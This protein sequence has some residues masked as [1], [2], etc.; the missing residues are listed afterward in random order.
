MMLG[1]MNL[2]FSR[3][4]HNN[5]RSFTD[6]SFVQ[7]WPFFALDIAKEIIYIQISSEDI[8]QSNC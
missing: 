6:Y 4:I 1:N 7:L 8:S 2:K 3:L 5:R